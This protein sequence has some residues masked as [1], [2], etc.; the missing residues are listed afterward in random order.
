VPVE[1]TNIDGVDEP[2]PGLV[3]VT[4]YETVRT[5]APEPD[6]DSEKEEE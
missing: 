6:G 1:D 3:R 5:I 4:E 2:A